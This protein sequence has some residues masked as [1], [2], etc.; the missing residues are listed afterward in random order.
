MET[1]L[2]SSKRCNFDLSADLF[3]D[4]VKALL[5]DFGASVLQFGHL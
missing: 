3:D 2:S 1:A 4:L 5:I